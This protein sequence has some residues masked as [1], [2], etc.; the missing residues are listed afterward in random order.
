MI[1]LIV[2]VE[3]IF[4]CGIWNYEGLFCGGFWLDFVFWYG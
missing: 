4:G 3:V 2:F 1:E